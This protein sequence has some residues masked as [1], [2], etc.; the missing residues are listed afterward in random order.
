MI[1]GFGYK[2]GV[3]RKSDPQMFDKGLIKTNKL[4]SAGSTLALKALGWGSLYAISGFTVFCCLVWKLSGAHS[5]EEFRANAGK[6][7]PK[8]PKNDPPQGRTE[9]SGLNDLLQY[10]ID[11]DQR[12]KN[13]KE[14]S[15]S[16]P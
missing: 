16:N 15:A 10:V 5:M 11:E 2:L 1:S 14:T 4:H 7:M 12:I 3:A 9:F 6:L 13:E 8:I